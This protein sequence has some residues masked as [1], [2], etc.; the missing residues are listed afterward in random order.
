MSALSVSVS[1]SRDIGISSST[2][3]EKYGFQFCDL[4]LPCYLLRLVMD[5]HVPHVSA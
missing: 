4:G 2:F 1:L 3:G 5:P